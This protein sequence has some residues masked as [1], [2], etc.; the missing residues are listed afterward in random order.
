LAPLAIDL[1]RDESMVCIVRAVL[2]AIADGLSS[3]IAGETKRTGLQPNQLIDMHFIPQHRHFRTTVPER[4]HI[5]PGTWKRLLRARSWEKTPRD[6]FGTGYPWLQSSGNT[7]PSANAT[8]PATIDMLR[9]SEVDRSRYWVDMEAFLERRVLRTEKETRR[10]DSAFATELL[11]YA[12]SK[13]TML[14]SK[15]KANGHGD[16]HQTGATVERGIALIEAAG[17][18]AIRDFMNAYG[19]DFAYGGL[20]LPKEWGKLFT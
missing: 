12:S 17:E 9:V 14:Q 16:R 3:K 7:F 8:E 2:R 20:S 6:A 19:D 4:F 11:A 13:K 15:A 1:A 5:L 18:Q 10:R